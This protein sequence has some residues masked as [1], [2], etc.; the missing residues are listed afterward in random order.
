MKFVLSEAWHGDSLTIKPSWTKGG[1]GRTLKIV[2]DS[3]RQWLNKVANLVKPKQSLIPQDRTYKQH[4]SHYE[5]QSKAI[6]I[7]KLHGLRHAYAQQRYF[8]LTKLFDPKNK[9]FACPIA[10]GKPTK[11]LTASEKIIDKKAREIL[12]RD[13]GHSRISVT[14]IYCG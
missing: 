10:G 8:E 7:H 11:L 13:L 4:L 9:G 5:A 12:S 6:G 3:Q 1:V 2:N 14:R